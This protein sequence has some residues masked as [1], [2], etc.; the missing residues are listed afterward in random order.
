MGKVR[1]E[2]LKQ[3]KQ[4]LTARELKFVDSYVRTGNGTQAVRD[5]GYKC[6]DDNARGQHAWYLLKKPKILG[7]I[8]DM[9]KRAVE[10]QQVTIDMLASQL[11]RIGFAKRTAIFDSLGNVIPPNEWPEELQT[12]VSGLE[13]EEIKEWDPELREKVVVGTKYKVRF[14][15]S[16]EALKTLAQWKGMVGKDAQPTKANT[17]QMVIS[18]DADPDRLIP[19]T[20][21]DGA[22]E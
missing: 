17:D 18:G 22:D 7:A 6:K 19:L 13:V 15:N 16:I 4:A 10:A 11:K 8:R 9:Q 21:A 20:P 1:E 5:A 2:H 14:Q 3:A 12:I